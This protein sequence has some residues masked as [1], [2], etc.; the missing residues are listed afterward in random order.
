MEYGPPLFKSLSPIAL[1]VYA[2]PEHTART[3]EALSKS[4]LS[5]QS[6]VYIFC[7]GH[8][9]SY[10]IARVNEVRSLVTNFEGF[11]RKTVVM[12]ANNIGLARSIIDGVSTV[13][14]N[15]GTVI[16]IEDDIVV[17]RE[18]LEFFNEAL[19]TYKTE[20]TVMHISGYVP[21]I[22]ARPENEGTFLFRIPFCWGWA[23]WEDR[24]KMF[25]PDGQL[26]LRELKAKKL[27]NRFDIDGTAQFTRMLQTQIAGEI[28]SW[29]VRWYATTLLASGLAIYPWNSVVTNIGNDG[30]WHTLWGR[31]TCT[32]LRYA[33]SHDT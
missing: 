1:F 2:R 5:A 14:A 10:D 4:N 21:G 6:E 3:L 29:F 22:V 32:R 20:T 30:V 33:R 23:T 12:R 24:W 9:G 7:D 26:L 17:G 28:D 31:Q 19:A 18:C 13:I 25:C 11:G 27:I 15:H 8:K 16:V